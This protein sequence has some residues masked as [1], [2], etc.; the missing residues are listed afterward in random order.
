MFSLTLNAPT[1]VTSVRN[2]FIAANA[3][4]AN[5]LGGKLQ[6]TIQTNTNTTGVIIVVSGTDHTGAAYANA[7]ASPPQGHQLV[8][9][10]THPMSYTVSE[11]P[12]S[13]FVHASTTGAPININIHSDK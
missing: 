13:V 11:N 5:H 12:D 9:D 10:G 3:A 1:T 7:S 6:T 2:L 4:Y 8:G